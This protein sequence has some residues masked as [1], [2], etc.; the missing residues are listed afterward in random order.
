MMVDEFPGWPFFSG[1]S[2]RAPRQPSWLDSPR[3][4]TA[5]SRGYY[6]PRSMDFSNHFSPFSSFGWDPFVNDPPVVQKRPKSSFTKATQPAKSKKNSKLSAPAQTSSSPPQDVTVAAQ[7]SSSPSQDVTVAAQTSSSTG[8]TPQ[9]VAISEDKALPDNTTDTNPSNTSSESLTDSQDSDET[10][11]ATLAEQST[12]L[13][14]TTETESN[15]RTNELPAGGSHTSEEPTEMD[16]QPEESSLQNGST[17][18]SS[19]ELSTASTSSSED[20]EPMELS[21]LSKEEIDKRLAAVERVKQQA[22]QLKEQ[23]SSFTGEKGSK[24]FIYLDESLL[25]L[26]LELDKVETMG[27][28]SIRKARKQTVLMIQQ[29]HNVLE[30]R[31]TDRQ[32]DRL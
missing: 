19:D 32:I 31:A 29:L 30:S 4:Y 23:V 20:D 24:G 7:T 3:S 6:Y 14:T 2:A 10:E 21:E 26:L 22:E 25:G 13:S 5:P 12:T 9:D 16:S 11:R 17:S 28:T 27:C 15:T 8:S 18:V 1:P